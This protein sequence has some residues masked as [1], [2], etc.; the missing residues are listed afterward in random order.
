MSGEWVL[1]IVLFSIA[2]WVLAGFMI[3]DLAGRR[4]VLGAHK[5]PWAIMI[6]F[7]PALGS[8]LYL[9]FHPQILNPDE[10]EDRTPRS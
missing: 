9:V 1:R 5:A 2:H 10:D 4:R 8:I 7:V 6:I 3:V